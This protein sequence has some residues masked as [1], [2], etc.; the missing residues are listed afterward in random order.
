MENSN[1]IL[2]STL[3]VVNNSINNFDTALGKVPIYHAGHNV[4]GAISRLIDRMVDGF[5]E[6]KM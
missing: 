5:S 2:D 1:D 4:G 6:H 3:E